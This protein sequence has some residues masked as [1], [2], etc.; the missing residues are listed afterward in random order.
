M[1]MQMNPS[2]DLRPDWACQSCTLVNPH[3]EHHCTA[4]GAQKDLGNLQREKENET[5][6]PTDHHPEVQVFQHLCGGWFMCLVW[7]L[8]TAISVGFIIFMVLSLDVLNEI[9][10]IQCNVTAYT[11]RVGCSY[12]CKC[13]SCDTTSR[14]ND[15]RRRFIPRCQT[16]R[17]AAKYTVM[18]TTPRCPGVTLVSHERYDK[19]LQAGQLPSQLQEFT[20]GQAPSAECWIAGCDQEWWYTSRD[21]AGSTQ[22]AGIFLG[23]I[24]G[25]LF[26]SLGS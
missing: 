21:S 11:Q 9:E 6:A 24:G 13:T 14:F 4:C 8:V 5:E 26:L 15:C 18:V 20:V 3:N 23:V 12:Q 7:L 17:D 19:C 2:A 22:N 1:S 16:C 10:S 25:V